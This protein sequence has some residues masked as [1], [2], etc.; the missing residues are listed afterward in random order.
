[1][2]N[3][4]IEKF[5]LK[6]YFKKN[7]KIVD[8]ALDKYL[9]SELTY[10][11]SIH[12]AMRYSIFAGGKRLRAILV[13]AGYEVFSSEKME[14]VLP[15]ACA[16]EMIHTYSLIH[17]DLPC[18]DNDDLRR[19]KPTNHKVFG[20]A[21]AVLAGDALLTHAFWLLAE[22]KNA[23]PEVLIKISRIIGK[24]VSTYGMIGGQVV[25]IESS[26]QIV[27]PET[28]EYIHIHKTSNLLQAC[29]HAG[30][31]MAGAGVKELKYISDY[32]KNIGLAFQIVDDILDIEGD[33]KLLGKTT[34]SDLI[35]KKNTYPS[36]FGLEKSKKYRDKL[37]NK[38]II[39]AEKLGQNGKILTEIAV[40][41][42]DRKF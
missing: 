3:I 27:K 29:I 2:N 15:I 6:K 8:K 5:N 37:I 13:I 36:L 21:I 35:N 32:G 4:Q 40:F 7:K 41:I 20:E 28:L 19:G 33:D 10:P 22:C 12:K 16:V 25:D 11:E 18:I 31:V 14:K 39:N 38:A 9:P 42:R 1:M 30:A 34:G 24:A 23:K 17:D 26:G